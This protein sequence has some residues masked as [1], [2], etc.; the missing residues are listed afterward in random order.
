MFTQSS[1]YYL[2]YNNNLS[3]YVTLSR[4]TSVTGWTVGTTGDFSSDFNNYCKSVGGMYDTF[5]YTF[6][7]SSDSKY[8][9]LITQEVYSPGDPVEESYGE[10]GTYGTAAKTLGSNVVSRLD[11]LNMGTRPVTISDLKTIVRRVDTANPTVKSA[12]PMATTAY[13]KG[14]C[15][16]ISVIYNEPINSISGTPKLTL[17]SSTLGKY[18]ESP[19]YVDNG[20]GTNTLVFKVK[21]KKDISADEIQNKVNLYLCFP[22]SGVGGNFSSNIGTLSATVKDILGN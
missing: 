19:T 8:I 7:V 6:K 22:V 4:F 3:E 18:F 15:A 17:A 20:T 14:D 11:F 10:V 21:A 12:A 13:K 5:Q 9:S 16:Y 1:T 2:L